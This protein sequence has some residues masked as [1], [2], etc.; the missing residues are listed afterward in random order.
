MLA[1]IRK[2]QFGE[3]TLSSSSYEKSY[4]DKQHDHLV[5]YKDGSDKEIEEIIEFCDPRI[6]GI[7]QSI[8]EAFGVKIDN[9]SL[10]FYGNKKNNEKNLFLLFILFAHFR[11][12]QIDKLNPKTLAYQ[13]YFLQKRKYTNAA[14]TQKIKQIHSDSINRKPDLYGG[15]M[16]FDGNVEFQHNGAVLTANRVVFYQKEN[17]VKA[18]GNVVLVTSDGNRITC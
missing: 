4:F 3:K 14:P 10:Y 9:H 1:L 15:N 5:I 11:L 12:A 8:E 17:F 16:F 2:H 6:Q 13:R 18:I 7:K